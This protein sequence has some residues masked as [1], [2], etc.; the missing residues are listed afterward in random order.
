MPLPSIVTFVSLFSKSSLVASLVATVF[1]DSGTQ[2]KIKKPWTGPLMET[3]LLMWKFPF[4]RRFH[5]AGQWLQ[6]YT[7]YSISNWSII[8]VAEE[9]LRNFFAASGISAMGA[10]GSG[11]HN[12]KC[13]VFSLSDQPFIIHCWN[14]SWTY[15]V[16]SFNHFCVK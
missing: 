12:S 14:R 7:V 1:S 5:R 2:L 10:S 8:C 9:W 16:Q 11:E 6:S 13:R 4:L 3:V 15:S